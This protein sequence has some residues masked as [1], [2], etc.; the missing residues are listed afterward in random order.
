MREASATMPTQMAHTPS[1]ND[2]DY[3]TNT[4]SGASR[5]ALDMR[6]TDLQAAVLL[7]APGFDAGREGARALA[8]LG[9]RVDMAIGAK[10]GRW[11][12]EK[13]H[14]DV[15]I[16]DTAVADL[17]DLVVATRAAVSCPMLVALTSPSI[18]TILP[19]DATLTRPLEASAAETT[20]SNWLVEELSARFRRAA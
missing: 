1:A 15:V 7:V 12:I 14:Y 19:F 6:T 11:H 18:A 13:R 20:I 10:D 2:S 9:H 16:L 5:S 4:G 17:H 3:G 8:R